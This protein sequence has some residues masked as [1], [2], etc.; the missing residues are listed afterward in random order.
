MPPQENQAGT[1]SN[2]SDAA[3]AGPSEQS[4]VPPD[5]QVE[6]APK[7]SKPTDS[8]PPSVGDTNPSPESGK[9]RTS[10][11]AHGAE[12]IEAPKPNP[13]ASAQNE[14]S[15]PKPP[16]P[17][18]PRNSDPIQHTTAQV[19][20]PPTTPKRSIRERL[21]LP[22]GPA[23]KTGVPKPGDAA[24]KQQSHS[25]P[26]QTAAKATASQNQDDA[27]QNSSTPTAKP[28]PAANSASN[29]SKA[30]TP[31]TVP[32]IIETP[33]FEQKKNNALDSVDIVVVYMC[34]KPDVFSG[35]SVFEYE[36]LQDESNR[37][38][39]SGKTPEMLTKKINWLS[40]EDMLPCILPSSRIIGFG[41]D[42]SV[43]DAKIDFKATAFALFNRLKS[44][45]ATG[46]SPSS[47]FSSKPI[48]F[49]GHG[50]GTVVIQELLSKYCDGKST[51]AST[52]KT[53]TA[54]VFLFAPPFRG[55]DNL[56][57][58]TKDKCKISNADLFF[59]FG[60]RNQA[61]Q[62]SWRDFNSATCAPGD[63]DTFVV[64]FLPNTAKDAE[65]MA[66]QAKG[67]DLSIEDLVS[68]IEY[69]EITTSVR[70]I[71]SSASS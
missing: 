38:A 20:Q 48:V 14:L 67:N 56:I 17:P 66:K 42:L 22:L 39:T 37:I 19:Q 60:N 45:R 58:W 5:P 8:N 15:P 27:A 61:P 54:A 53:S 16:P 21:H 49:I 10:A 26:D 57:K 32:T 69:L 1:L 7:S 29:K 50:Y 55:S 23:P 33:F 12:D 4:S 43:L 63:P 71:P 62:Q 65:K 24:Q 46:S 35:F 40:S 47:N 34:G 2:S 52:L 51:F 6:A 25:L 9:A 70:F 44:K 68:D 41:F 28:G 59:G 3:A 31:T 64:V 11:A 13:E 18:P 36:T 30:K